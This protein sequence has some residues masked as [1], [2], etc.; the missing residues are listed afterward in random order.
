M[1]YK[2]KH[3]TIYTYVNAVHN[4]QSIVCLQPQNSAKQTCSNFKIEIEPKP[5][6]IY[7]RK[8]FFGN[9]LHYFSLHESHK[10]LKVLVSS[11]IEVLND[12][13]QPLNPISCEDARKKFQTDHALKIEVLQYQ[14]PSQ[15]IQ[16]DEEIIAFAQS[17]LLPDI[18][19]FEGILNLIKKIYTE[20]QFKSGSTNINTPLKTVLKERKGVCQ[21]FSHLA[22]ASLRSVG[23]PA[24]YVSG[25][26]ETLPPKGKVK[27]EGSDASHAWISVYIPEMGWCEF[28]PTNNMIPQ[29]RHIVTAYGRD[30]AD[31][32]PLKGI[33]FSSGEHKVKVEVDVIPV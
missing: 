33:I 7:S 2:L 3:Q 30:F 8:D 11:D 31:V 28:D 19:L 1:K 9:T 24:R 18:S 25:Y 14:L 17:C 20:F 22:I 5:A 13:I 6:K 10:S 21:D 29:Q 16:W 26:I 4:Y 27:L 23:I 32:S 15:F 12:I